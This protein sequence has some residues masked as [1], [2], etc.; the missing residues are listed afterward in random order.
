[1]TE[2]EYREFLYNPDNIFN[3]V[4]CPDDKGMS[5]RE[6]G[7]NRLPCGQYHCWVA[8]HCKGGKDS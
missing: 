5:D 6:W 2:K 7:E 3:C 1:M 4:E 8:I